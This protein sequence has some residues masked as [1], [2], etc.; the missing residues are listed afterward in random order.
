[1]YKNHR[2]SYLF[3]PSITRESFVICFVF[4]AQMP[5]SHKSQRINSLTFRGKTI[6]LF[7]KKNLLFELFRRE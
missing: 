2:Q 6:F 7:N 1:M 4:K 3:G 5:L